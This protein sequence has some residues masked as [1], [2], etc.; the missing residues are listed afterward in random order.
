MQKRTKIM[1]IKSALS[2]SAL[3]LVTL[4][5][6]MQTAQAG[7]PVEYES[8][9]G[10]T[11]REPVVVRGKGI[12][13]IRGNTFINQGTIS[14]QSDEDAAMVDIRPPRRGE[15]IYI[16]NNRFINRGSIIQQ[17]GTGVAAMLHI[18]RERSNRKTRVFSSGNKSLNYG[19]IIKK[20]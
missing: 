10:Q 3:V 2:T 9:R 20:D 5:P 19:R 6:C 12:T 4:L 18:H 17:N 15:R 11:L 16:R 14:R 1:T 7:K 13:L 8:L